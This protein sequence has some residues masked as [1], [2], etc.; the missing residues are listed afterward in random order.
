MTLP[1]LAPADLAAFASIE[2]AKAQAMIDDATAMAVRVAPC[3]AIPAGQ[4]GALSDND[5]A[6]VKAVLRNA[7]LRW[8]DSGTGALA[9]LQQSAGSFSVSQTMDTR[10]PRRGLLWPT[11]INDLQAICKSGSE[12]GAFEI[13]TVPEDASILHADI[14]SINFGATY[15]SCG[16]ILTGRLPLYEETW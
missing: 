4:P 13:N 8:N 7:I 14:C 3:I 9:G 11:E 15:C 12:T 5:Q 6:A 10:S 2:P 1:I 16:A